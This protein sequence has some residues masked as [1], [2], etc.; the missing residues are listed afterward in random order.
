MGKPPCA[1]PSAPGS[2]GRVRVWADALRVRWTRVK[3]GADYD[4]SM[5]QPTDAAA[6]YLMT[7]RYM[8]AEVSR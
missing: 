3:Q 1:W 2:P 4:R 6:D 7:I 8:Q 5:S